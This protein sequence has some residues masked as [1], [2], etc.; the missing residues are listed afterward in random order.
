LFGVCLFLLSLGSF[1]CSR[2][3]PEQKKE[4]KGA[5]Q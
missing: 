4:E 5:R 2:F 1:G 3:P